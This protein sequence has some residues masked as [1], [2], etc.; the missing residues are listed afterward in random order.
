MRAAIAVLCLVWGCTTPSST[1]AW[2]D[3]DRPEDSSSQDDEVAIAPV[4]RVLVLGCGS[5]ALSTANLL[6]ASSIDVVTLCEADEVGGLLSTVAVGPAAVDEGRTWI[7]SGSS[8][9]SMN[10]LESAGITLVER[11]ERTPFVVEA[12]LGE[13]PWKDFAVS[14]AA[15]DEL[16]DTLPEVRDRVGPGEVVATGVDEWLNVVN[17]TEM[18][19]QQV[20]FLVSQQLVGLED[21]AN[22]DTVGLDAFQER[23]VSAD[24]ERFPLEG[25]GQLVDVLSDGLTI[26]TGLSIIS[27]AER[28]D[29]GVEVV[30]SAGVFT[31][32]HVVVAL[33][34]GVLQSGRVSIEPP[35]PS[36]H[37]AAQQGVGVGTIETVALVYE[38]AF[39]TEFLDRLALYVDHAGSTFP[40]FYDYTGVAGAPTL[41]AKVSGAAADE[42]L[43][44]SDEEIVLAATDVLEQLVDVK[45]VPMPT[46]HHISRWSTD[47]AQLGSSVFLKP[48]AT[49]EQ[50]EVL[51][52]PHGRIL[53][54]GSHTV[55]RFWGLLEGDLRSAAR[56]ADRLGA[57]LPGWAIP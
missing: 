8:P 31:G 44:L 15:L 36:W 29:V 28:P 3:S 1:D 2:T 43:T 6:H 37:L 56:E 23:S 18:T 7:R 12:T 14:R 50:L 55:P 51:G 16:I 9:V 47:P 27:V 24:D 17:A 11:P 57:S 46:A 54:A 40:V 39:W 25:F 30:T 48:G 41:L 34:V 5:A 26:E 49:S 45:P 52:R 22:A 4:E 35:L 19:R 42:L 38:E 33:P 13:V 32:S 20:R 10:L 53:F 21:G